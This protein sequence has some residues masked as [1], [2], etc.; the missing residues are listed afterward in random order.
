MPWLRPGRFSCPGVASLDSGP[1]ITGANGQPL[2]TAAQAEQILGIRARTVYEWRR[3]DYLA[4]VGL[5]PDGRELYDAGKLA[6]VQA[7]P[8][9]RKRV[10]SQSRPL[11]VAA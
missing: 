3:R 1:V 6:A 2:L 7:S 11:R 9:K 5:S 4:V 8:R 10:Q